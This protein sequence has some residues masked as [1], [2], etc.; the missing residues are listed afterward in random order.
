[1]LRRGI[2]KDV[3]RP[4]LLFCSAAL[5]AL[6]PRPTPSPERLPT[7]GCLPEVLFAGFFSG[8]AGWNLGI[9]GRGGIGP[10]DVCSRGPC[11][12]AGGPREDL[13]KGSFWFPPGVVAVKIGTGRNVGV[14]GRE[15]ASE[16]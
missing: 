13:L 5:F 14:E 4:V 3:G 2:P 8:E 7:A 1:M 15:D 6:I 10:V 12:G 9:G 16:D 11:V